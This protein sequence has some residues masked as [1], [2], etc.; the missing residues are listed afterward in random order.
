MMY[1]DKKTNVTKYGPVH[2]KESVDEVMRL[3]MS[4]SQMK[5]LHKAYDKL[6]YDDMRRIMLSVVKRDKFLKSLKRFDKSSL[7]QLVDMKPN[8]PFSK[9]VQA[10]VDGRIKESTLNQIDSKRVSVIRTNMPGYVG[11]KFAK[12]ASDEDILAMVDLKDQHAKIYNR[13]MKDINDKIQKLQKKYNIKES[14]NEAIKY[15]NDGFVTK[16]V[17]RAGKVVKDITLD[18]EKFVLKGNKYVSKKGG[19]DLHKSHFGIKESVSETEKLENA[20]NKITSDHNSSLQE[21][22]D[23]NQK[24]SLVSEMKY[25][26]QTG[27]KSSV[28]RDNE[29]S[30][31]LSPKEQKWARGNDVKIYKDRFGFT[32]T[33]GKKEMVF[34]LNKPYSVVKPMGNARS[35][36][37]KVYQQNESVVSEK[38]VPKKG[39]AD[40]HQHKIAVDTVKNPNKSFMGGPSAKE[41]EEI[42][43]KK[44]GY[45][46]KEVEKLNESL[47]TEAT[48]S[49]VGV[50]DKN[51]NIIST[52]VHLDGYPNGVGQTL[53]K[54]YD[55][56]KTKQLLKIA[57]KDGI[58]V[59]D[60][61]IKG[62]PGHTFDNRVKGQTLFYGRDR[63]DKGGNMIMKGKLDKIEDYIKSTEVKFGAEYV[64]LYDENSRKWFYADIGKSR[65]EL[66]PL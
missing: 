29:F 25:S 65:T 46:K 52:Y 8:S 33:D 53:K 38:K 11:T 23:T 47:L 14:V 62:A 64:Y 4:T 6:S 28:L 21:L 5:Q 60:R 24:S 49:Q 1:L 7:Q 13:Y 61:E 54:H 42:L 43:M 10:Y 22:D 56:A 31:L 44:F 20:Y 50:V 19:K 39:S 51:G 57:G 48:R 35:E 37:K 41:A 59:L 12:K 30:N 26:N 34:N 40:Y 36:I 18:G 66:Y 63:G 55:G 17:N 32:F 15:N 27:I 9:A 3:K 45:S 58:S 2:I 16:M